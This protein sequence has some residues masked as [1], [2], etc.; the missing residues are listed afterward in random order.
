M[1]NLVEQLLLGLKKYGVSEVFG[2]PGDFALSMFKVIEESKILPVYYFSHE[3]GVGFAADASTRVKGKPSAAVVTYGAGGFNMVNAIACAYAEKAPVIVISGGPGEREKDNGFLLH[4]QVKGFDSQLKVYKEI[5]VDQVIL[6]DPEKAPDQI[7][8]VLI[9]C[10][11]YSRPVYIEVPRD[12]VFNPCETV[13]SPPKMLWTVDENKVNACAKA[14][15]NKI[16][17]AEK[18]MII[19][20]IEIKR[21]GLEKQTAELSKKLDIPIV[22]T[23]M[24]RGLFAEENDIDFYGTYAGKGGNQSVFDIVKQSDLPMLFGVIFNDVNFA[25]SD[26]SIDYN[27]SVI[28]YD[29]TCYL[30][31]CSFDNVPLP[32]LIDAL[33]KLSKPQK[34]TADKHTFMPYTYGFVSDGKICTPNDVATLLN[35][36]FKTHGNMWLVTDMGDAFFTAL[37]VH[38]TNMLA[39]AFYATMGYGV[40]AGFGAQIASGERPIILVGDGA[41]QMTGWEVLNMSRYKLNPIIMVF[42]NAS[43]EMLRT[44]QPESEFNNLPLLDFKAIAESLGGIGHQVNNRSDLKSAF[45]NALNDESKFHILDIK[46]EKEVLSNT[47]S[48]FVKG[49]KQVL[50]GS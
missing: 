33:L 32:L 44:F 50:S 8:R 38:N 40:P 14:I 47:L 15:L 24:A 46:I 43:W 18:P 19:A 17:K 27:T 30:D 12:Q 41:F 36:T 11:R 7:A 4:H 42:N 6:S 22:T 10:L 31:H 48:G 45:E 3:P 21:Y 2:I 28:T 37:D 1:K 23:L 13:P 16:S 5:T 49:M 39:P 29:E 20:G 35:D 9:N 34:R 25:L 26:D